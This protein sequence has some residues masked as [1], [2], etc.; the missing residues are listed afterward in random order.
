MSTTNSGVHSIANFYIGIRSCPRNHYFW[1]KK[2]YQL[3]TKLILLYV[4][5]LVD[6]PC[7]SYTL[8]SHSYDPVILLCLI[9]KGLFP[10]LGPTE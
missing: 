8:S 1:E 7:Q 6:F 4:P 10:Y 2:Y 5:N 3:F 9:L